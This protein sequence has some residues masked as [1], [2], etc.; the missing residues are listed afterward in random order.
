MK[1]YSFFEYVRQIIIYVPVNNII[2]LYMRSKNK[3][4]SDHALAREN[5][6]FTLCQ[7]D[8]VY[9]PVINALTKFQAF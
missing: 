4:F 1:T 6:D 7:M 5:I 9:A 8:G 3:Y 2:Y